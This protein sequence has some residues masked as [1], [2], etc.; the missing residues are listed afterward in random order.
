MQYAW[1]H[2]Q[3]QLVG[4]FAAG[5][6]DQREGMGLLEHQAMPSMRD[7]THDMHEHN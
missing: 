5:G 1:L 4:L 7:V 3:G 6:Q 2:D